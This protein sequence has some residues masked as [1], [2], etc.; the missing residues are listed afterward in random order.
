M[1]IIIIISRPHSHAFWTR[2]RVKAI[3]IDGRVVSTSD[4][5]SSGPGSIPGGHIS[6]FFFLFFSL[7]FLEVITGVFFCFFSLF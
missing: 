1:F 2:S 7:F 4:S 6:N 3:Y 5:E